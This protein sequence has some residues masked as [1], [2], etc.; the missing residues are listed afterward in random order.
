[1]LATGD[2]TSLKLTEYHKTYSILYDIDILRLFVY[3]IVRNGKGSVYHTLETIINNKSSLLFLFSFFFV[4]KSISR[5]SL[6]RASLAQSSVFANILNIFVELF[7][8][9][10]FYLNC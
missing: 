2:M 3:K 8:K 10:R 9:L 5:T 7:M 4:K 1:M 6:F